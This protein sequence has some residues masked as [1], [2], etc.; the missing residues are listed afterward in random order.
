MGE[1]K[2]HF[3]YLLLATIAIILFTVI[4]TALI[5]TWV[6]LLPQ[7]NATDLTQALDDSLFP[8]AVLHES[9]SWHYTAALHNPVSTAD[10]LK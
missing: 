1:N 2:S 8:Y 4:A 10:C 5:V 3:I 9:I 7:A 6:P